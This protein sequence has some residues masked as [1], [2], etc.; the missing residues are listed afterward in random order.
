MARSGVREVPEEG[1]VIP[2]PKQE[3]FPEREGNPQAGAQKR[4][5]TGMR[6]QQD[7]GQPMSLGRGPALDHEGLG[8]AR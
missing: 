8:E 7:R 5:E 4:V 3:E 6:K 1:S 2:R